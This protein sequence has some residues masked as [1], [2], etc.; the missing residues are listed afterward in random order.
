MALRPPLE[1]YTHFHITTTLLVIAG[2]IYLLPKTFLF[3]KPCKAA[4]I[5]CYLPA[6]FKLMIKEIEEIYK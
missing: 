2:L 1:F 4:F 6:L 3:I 5:A